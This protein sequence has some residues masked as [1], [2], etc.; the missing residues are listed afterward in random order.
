[1]TEE[2]SES[3]V[4]EFELK[5]DKEDRRTKRRKMKTK[6]KTLGRGRGGE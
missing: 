2:S 1:M 4:R 3:I 6:T 5:T